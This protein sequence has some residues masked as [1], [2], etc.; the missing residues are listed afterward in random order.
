MKLKNVQCANARAVDGKS[1]RLSD[2]ENLYLVVHP[3]GRKVWQYRYS[4]AVEGRRPRQNVATLGDYVERAPAGE[5]EEEAA[6]RIAGRMLT[7]AE[8]RE[9]ARKARVL[10]RQ[11]IHPTAHRK[12]QAQADRAARG[13]VFEAVAEEW[14]KAKALTLRPSSVTRYRYILA[15]LNADLGKLPVRDI[16]PDMLL[17][18]LRKNSAYGARYAKVVAAGVFDYAVET[19]LIEVSPV[20]A[21]KTALPPAK[22]THKRPL[23]VD[24]VGALLR[25]VKGYGGHPSTIRAMLW[26]W[27]TLGR[28]GEVVGARWEEIDTG[29]R[30]WV[31]PA[32]RM[33][34]KREHVVPLPDQAMEAL[35]EWRVTPVNAGPYLFQI[36]RKH[37]SI[38]AITYMI[39]VIGWK[40]RFS[41]H[42]ARTTF[43]TYMHEI[44]ERP[45][46]VERQLA[47]AVGNA[48]AR[49][50]N[51]STQEELRRGMMQKWADWLD[52][53]QSGPTSG[54]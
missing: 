34:A 45:D 43:S 12:Q 37:V 39:E 1:V 53:W 2:G 29:R 14:V 46:L 16:T 50:Y 22:A 36:E 3:S 18:V 20:R 24:E 49:A 33:K 41:A 28:I 19:S 38:S 25:D 8:A 17:R 11:G 47:H 54:A 52:D 7:L 31:I 42:A 32:E 6:R 5:S 4:M 15:D 40:G 35:E 10:V 27:W 51:R 13:H 9:E 48:V 23:S 21:W 26:V 44:G 30:V